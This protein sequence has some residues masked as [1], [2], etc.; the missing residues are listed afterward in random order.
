M[1]HYIH[2]PVLLFVFLLLASC[3]KPAVPSVGGGDGERLA[4]SVDFPELN[5]TKVQGDVDDLERTV[6]DIDVVVYRV[7][8]GEAVVDSYYDFGTE[9]SGVVHVWTDRPADSYRF[10]AYANCSIGSEDCEA[11]WTHFSDEMLGSFRMHGHQERSLS[12]LRESPKVTVGLERQVCKVSVRKISLRWGNPANAAKEFSV[13]A[14]YLTD[15]MGTLPMQHDVPAEC[16]EA[17]WNANGHVEGGQDALLYEEVGL[18]LADGGELTL[19]SSMYGYLSPLQVFNSSADWREGGTRLVIEARHGTEV[20]YYHVKI[21]SMDV[22]T[23]RNK[24]FVFEEI[25]ITKPGAPA[26]YAEYPEEDPIEVSC[27]VKEW[28]IVDR[29]TIDIS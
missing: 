23:L 19:G 11:D 25:I 10:V 16:C 20:V 2:I 28:D 9:T 27:S 4:V 18:A 26:P 8:G 29:G 1:R 21:N 7:V 12:A 15:V 17:W 5:A 14:V 3:Q 24:H 22:R 13:A 6:N